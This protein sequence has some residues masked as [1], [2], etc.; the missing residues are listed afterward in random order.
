MGD[1]ILLFRGCPYIVL[2]C[3]DL[4]FWEGGGGEV[5]VYSMDLKES[6]II[7]NLQKV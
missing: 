1:S 3:F 2:I 6:L 7:E 4:D 5:A